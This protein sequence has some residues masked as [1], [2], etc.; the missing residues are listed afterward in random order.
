MHIMLSGTIVSHFLWMLISQHVWSFVALYQKPIILRNIKSFNLFSH[1]ATRKLIRIYQHEV[2][3]LDYLQLYN[4]TDQIDSNIYLINSYL[5]CYY[6]F[7]SHNINF[8][9]LQKL[10]FLLGKIPLICIKRTMFYLCFLIVLAVQK[11]SSVL[12]TP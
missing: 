3:C 2:E 4:G 6:V 9:K 5:L 1:L 8:I 7:P 11:I 10:E 12:L